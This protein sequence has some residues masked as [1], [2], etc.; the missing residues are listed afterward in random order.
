MPYGAGVFLYATVIIFVQS[1][2]YFMAFKGGVQ[3]Y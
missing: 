1:N 2:S 3:G